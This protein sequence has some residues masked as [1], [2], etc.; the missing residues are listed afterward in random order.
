M[1]DH[2]HK[3]DSVTLEIQH[4][5]TIISGLQEDSKKVKTDTAN[6]IDKLQ[7]KHSMMYKLLQQRLMPIDKLIQI[8]NKKFETRE[9]SFKKLEAIESEMIRLQTIIIQSINVQHVTDMVVIST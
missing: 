1:K 3:T 8:F 5:S 7:L 4:L 2:P 9:Q 6:T